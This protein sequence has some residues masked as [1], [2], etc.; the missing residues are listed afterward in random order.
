MGEKRTQ[1]QWAPVW[2]ARALACSQAGMQVNRE[3][4]PKRLK[5]ADC[6]CTREIPF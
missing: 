3:Q 1:E 6:R 5:E 2:A 4:T